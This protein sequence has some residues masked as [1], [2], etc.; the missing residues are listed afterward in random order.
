MK[1]WIR[2]LVVVAVLGV[3]LTG[4]VA[5]IP[6]AAGQ[7]PP[8]RVGVTP[9]YP[10]LIFRQGE[11]IT[12]VEADLAQRLGQE[13]KRPVTLVPLTWEDQIPAL[14]NNKIDIIMSG[15][16]VTPARQ[17][18]IRF[19]E[20]YLKTGLVAAFRA[21]DAWKYPSKEALL[22]SQAVVAAPEGTTG[23]AFV[24]RNFAAG[25]RKVSL[26]KAS[27]A[28]AELKRRYIDVFVHDAPYILWMI[29]ENEAYLAALWDTFTREDV[30][31]GVRKGDDAFAAQVDQAVK[32]WKADGSLDAV[33]SKWL[34]AAY[35][36]YFK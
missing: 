28:A 15:M 11:A 35:L 26:P 8:L 3:V 19:A 6:A 32:K 25:T 20:P 2:D 22:N 14:L 21:E 1:V 5:A 29:S 30:A 36:K 12:G 9:N 13:L 16:S 34:P 10:P 17:V 24:K 33:L 18:R 31:W 23:D 7:A 27:T 4:M